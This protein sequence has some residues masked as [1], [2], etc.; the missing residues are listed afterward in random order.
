[1]GNLPTL[2]LDLLR[3]LA[4]IAEEGSFTRAAERVGRT[5]SAVSLQVQRLEARIGHTLITR[6]KG[7]GVELTARGEDL[8]ARGRELL[9]LNDAIVRSL[10]TATVDSSIRFGAD[11]GYCRPWI[12]SIL[13]RFAATHP[14]VKVEISRDGSCELVP[15]LKAGEL[16]LV[17]C[18]GGHEPRQWPATEV[19]R[20]RLAWI[21]SEAH[22]RHLDDPLP[23]VLVPGSCPLRPPWLADC[24]WRLAPIGA[25]ER[26]GL[27]YKIVSTFATAPSLQDAVIAGLGVSVLPAIGRLPEGLRTTRL[28]ERL[29]ELPEVSLMLLKAR[30]PRQPLT[31]ALAA[32]IIEAFGV[33]THHA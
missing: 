1:M 4:L 14:D 21:T 22:R 3:T 27:R 2:D 8:V 20:G 28:D 9:A 25:L 30:E 24:L 6:G 13:T 15:R 10:D 5:Q 7:G 29:P 31:D 16:D 33:T 19:W 26:A 17:L 11:G 23:L 32:H 18:E 12:P